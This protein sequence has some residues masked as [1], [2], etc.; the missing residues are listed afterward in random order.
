MVRASRLQD[1]EQ[2]HLEH[3]R[4][5]RRND[6]AA[7]LVAVGE[8]GRDGEAAL[9]ADFHAL[10]AFV[11]AADDVAGAEGEVERVAA[12][13]A[14]VELLSVCHAPDVVHEDVVAERGGFAPSDYA[15]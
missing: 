4:R 1:F 15:G 3:Q 5:L 12:V 7:A 8:G 6:A 2:L 14:R 9:A 11:P 10:D 13:D